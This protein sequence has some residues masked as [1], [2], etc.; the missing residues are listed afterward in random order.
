L[1]VEAKHFE[2]PKERET[3]EFSAE[4]KPGVVDEQVDRN[5]TARELFRQDLACSGGR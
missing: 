5:T 2:L 3:A 4:T 1:V